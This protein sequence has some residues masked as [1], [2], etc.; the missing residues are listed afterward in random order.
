MSSPLSFA[1]QIN[2]AGTT[3]FVVS[4]AVTRSLKDALIITVAHGLAHYFAG[5]IEQ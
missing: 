4:Y 1:Q 5:R 2:I 3:V